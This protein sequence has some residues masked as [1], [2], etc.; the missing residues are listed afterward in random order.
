MKIYEHACA[1]VLL[2]DLVL[3]V[4]LLCMFRARTHIDKRPVV[5]WGKVFTPYKSTT[6]I[7]QEVVHFTTSQDLY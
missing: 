6:D 2:C 3:I 1:T 4:L 5:E 7:L